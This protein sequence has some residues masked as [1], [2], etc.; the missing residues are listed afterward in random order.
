MAHWRHRGVRS[1]ERHVA[2]ANL[3]TARGNAEWTQL[4]GWF[5]ARDWAPWRQTDT[6]KKLKQQKSTF[7]PTPIWFNTIVLP[8][9]I[10]GRWVPLKN[11]SP[12]QVSAAAPV[13]ECVPFLFLL[14][15]FYLFWHVLPRSLCVYMLCPSQW[16]GQPIAPDGPPTI[17]PTAPTPTDIK[18]NCLYHVYHVSMSSFVRFSQ[19]FNLKQENLLTSW[20]QAKT[21]VFVQ[22]CLQP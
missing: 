6:T 12:P 20:T 15:S 11:L 9:L 7:T 17:P 8:F 21:Y 16:Q 19:K 13:S 18:K 10:K 14:F 3:L 4:G 2:G 22:K 1:E 5:W